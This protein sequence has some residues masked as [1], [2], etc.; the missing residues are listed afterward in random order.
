M[1]R[2]VGAHAVRQGSIWHHALAPSASAGVGGRPMCSASRGAPRGFE[3]RPVRFRVA[4]GQARVGSGARQAR[5]R[6]F[7]SAAASRRRDAGR[8]HAA[9]RS[10]AA[11]R[12][13]RPDD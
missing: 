2:P 4:F 13:E 6:R 7:M 12:S 1:P 8:L 3:G 5:S 9:R 10:E 11:S